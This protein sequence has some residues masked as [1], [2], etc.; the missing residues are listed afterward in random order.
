MPAWD[1]LHL[2]KTTNVVVANWVKRY[3]GN[4]FN[5]CDLITK[6]DVMVES[7]VSNEV[8]CKLLVQKLLK[9]KHGFANEEVKLKNFKSMSMAVYSTWHKP[10]VA[11]YVNG[12]L[13]LHEKG[14]ICQHH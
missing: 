10:D 5:L 4:N 6:H 1:R 8:A 11:I 14:V 9:T 13:V 3:T 7:S 12:K 2:L